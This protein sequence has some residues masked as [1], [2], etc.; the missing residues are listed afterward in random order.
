M[1]AS[2][3][4]LEMVCLWSVIIFFLVIANFSIIETMQSF[5]TGYGSGTGKFWAYNFK[6]ITEL[7]TRCVYIGKAEGEVFPGLAW[8]EQCS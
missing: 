4:R 6:T 5:F 8:H 3:M 2:K 7:A 1:V